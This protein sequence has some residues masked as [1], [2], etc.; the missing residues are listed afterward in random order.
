MAPKTQTLKVESIQNNLRSTRRLAPLTHASLLAAILL[1]GSSLKGSAQDIGEGGNNMGFDMAPET[2]LAVVEAAMRQIPVQMAP[3]PFEPSWDSLKQNYKVPDWFIGA[4]FGIFLHFGIFSVPA[5]QSEWYEKFMYAGG[6][7]NT[8]KAMRNH[9]TLLPWHTAHFGPPDKF[10][11]KDFIPMFK[12]EKFDADAWALLFK[13]AGARYVVP[14]AQHHENFAMWDSEVTPFN[15]MQM[16][17]KRDVI[18]ELA[19]AVRKQGMKLGLANHGIEN[20]QF[21]NPPPDLAARLKAEKVDLFD[22]KWADFY[23]YADRSDAAC[24]KFLVNWYERNVE[25][26][27][28]YHP[29]LLYFDNG[30]DQ[31]Y[32]DPLKLSIAAYY[33]NRAKSWGK[34]VSLTTKKA[35]FSPTDKN[36]ETIGSIIDF[37]GRTPKGIR[38]G[39]WQEDQPVGSSWGY[40]TGM[41]INSSDVVI[42]WLVEA[43]S[44]NGSLLLNVSP[45]ADGTIPQ[46]QQNTLLGVGKWLETN[47][48]AIYD[49]HS[50]IKF[51]ETG[52][53]HTYFTVKGDVL[54]AILSGKAHGSHLIITSL[55]QGQAPSGTITSVTMLGGGKKPLSFSQDS[56][57]L[58][59]KLPASARADGIYTLKITGLKMNPP[60]WTVSGDPMQGNGV[61]A[62]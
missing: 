13:R 33:Y 21:I 32:L 59:V 25:L 49:T 17:P 48:E 3:G 39:S 56:M 24:Q 28:K 43:V 20:F 29:D 60:T 1:V 44:K 55:A 30:I 45:M 46:E 36:T 27:D 54:Y 10:G 62:K 9:D 14:G 11:Y 38:T 18:G 40:V 57:G 50:W 52:K 7:D 34:E 6:D 23:N 31:R 37:E 61:A 41:R 16:G 47:G 12:A 51:E 19:K 22:P 15:A 53:Q 2:N 4:K 35:A 58:K 5:H 26:I 8:L 42:S